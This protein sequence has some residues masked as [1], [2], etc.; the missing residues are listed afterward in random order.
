MDEIFC[1]GCGKKLNTM[2]FIGDKFF[3]LQDGFYCEVCA[4]VVVEQRRKKLTGGKI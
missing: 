3:Q 2:K 1:K 4:K